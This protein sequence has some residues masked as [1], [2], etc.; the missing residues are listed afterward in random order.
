MPLKKRRSPQEKKLL[1]L[2]LDRR[3]TYGESDKGSR[4]SVPR[5]KK[6]IRRTLRRKANAALSGARD[7]AVDGAVDRAPRGRRKAPGRPLAQ[8]VVMQRRARKLRHG[9][10]SYRRGRRASATATDEDT[11]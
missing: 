1:S 9:G 2:S 8:H 6:R 5:K 11:G 4:K 3:E 7:D 10:K